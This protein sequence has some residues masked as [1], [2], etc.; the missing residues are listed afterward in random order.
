MS[1]HLVHLVSCTLCTPSTL[2]H[3]VPCIVLLH[4][5]SCSIW[6]CSIW[7]KTTM[8]SRDMNSTHIKHSFG[9]NLMYVQLR[10]FFHWVIDRSI[11]LE[12]FPKNGFPERFGNFTIPVSEQVFDK[13]AGWKPGTLLKKRLRHKCFPLSF[14]KFWETPILENTYKWLVLYWP[15]DEEI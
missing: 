5:N 10:S 11:R 1:S 4:N 12:V 13:V 7:S 8:W 3:L 6:S 2:V 14:A 9:C 15:K